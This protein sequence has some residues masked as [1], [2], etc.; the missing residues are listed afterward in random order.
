M[1]NES[2]TLEEEYGM[3]TPQRF[4]QYLRVLVATS[5][6]ILATA[7]ANAAVHYVTQAGAGAKNG[8]NWANAYDEAAFPAAIAG[9]VAGEE[10]WVKKGVYR[11]STTND[12]TASF[13]LKN[14]VALYGGFNGNETSSAG[15]MARNTGTRSGGTMR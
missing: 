1:R 6:M 14:G 2:A 4:R 8:L 13:V 7:T 3:T 15:R 5:A 9:A 11:P 12:A 10:F